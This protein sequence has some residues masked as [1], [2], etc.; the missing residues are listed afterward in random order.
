METNPRTKYERYAPSLDGGS[1]E[2]PDKKEETKKK[3]SIGPRD[4]AAA[5]RPAEQDLGRLF[6]SLFKKSSE[7]QPKPPKDEPERAGHTKDDEA[8]LDA[9]EPAEPAPGAAEARNSL[10]DKKELQPDEERL[11]SAKV[12]EAL[13]TKIQQANLDIEAAPTTPE[14]R[15]AAF[16][17]QRY[18]EAVEADLA[19]KDIDPEDAVNIPYQKAVQEL[20]ALD[21]TPKAVE[22]PSPETVEPAAMP[23]ADGKVEQLE[24]A[25]AGA[26]DAAPQPEAAEGVLDSAEPDDTAAPIFSRTSHA[27]AG[28]AGPAVPPPGYGR[29]AWHAA[30]PVPA[31]AAVAH[32]AGTERSGPTAGDVLTAGIFGLLIGN[33]MGARRARAKAEKKFAPIQKKL[34]S[35]VRALQQTIIGNTEHIQRLAR[36]HAA[37]HLPARAAGEE[38]TRIAPA[39]AAAES[40]IGV[41]SAAQ[42]AERPA[43][44]G[45]ERGVLLP[46]TERLGSVT[47]RAAAEA[48]PFAASRPE[49]AKEAVLAPRPV[50][51]EAMTVAQLLEASAAITV[52]TTTLREAVQAGQL[53]ISEAGLRHVVAEAQRPGGEVGRVLAEEVQESTF[54]RDPR[55]RAQ[56]LALL[57]QGTAADTAGAQS[58]AAAGPLADE[59][60]MNMRLPAGALPFRGTASSGR[61]PARPALVAANAVALAVLAV[62]VL[63]LIIVRL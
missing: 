19:Q 3:K 53:N 5:S 44:H 36:E 50:R 15:A 62:L 27:A 54:E 43:V 21:D 49:A 12:V 52:G 46:S 41:P 22:A 61:R 23:A 18:L 40:R 56:Q 48:R 11:V 24:D 29:T 30:G 8:E 35:E 42:Q 2:D 16:A 17:G 55:L 60:S 7:D 9:L 32:V 39:A 47:L 31:P 45:Q 13:E 37:A 1:S 6:D 58:T 51:V 34:E 26:M 63:I 14:D 28:M 10:E 25:A 57:R 33:F 20:A 4:A 38:I 59:P